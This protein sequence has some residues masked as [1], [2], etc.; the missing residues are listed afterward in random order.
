MRNWEHV[1][2]AIGFIITGIVMAWY[3]WARVRDK[4][5]LFNGHH[6]VTLYWV[7]YLSCFVLGVT[8]GAAALLR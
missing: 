6:V 4:R 8:S 5:P 1:V 3:E 2:A 7:A